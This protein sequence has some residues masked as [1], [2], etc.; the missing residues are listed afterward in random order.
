MITLSEALNTYVATNPR[1]NS[2]GTIRRY[3]AT[4]VSLGKFL[5]R[6]PLIADLNA[7][8]YGRWVRHRRDVVGV[9]P[10]TL[11]GEAQKLLVIWRWLAKR[12]EVAQPDVMLPRKFEKD[13]TTWVTDE[14]AKIEA[15]GRSCDWYVGQVP[16]SIYWPAMLGVAVESGER[17]GALHKLES[18]HFDFAAL[19]VTFPRHIRKGQT[20]DLTKSISL[21]T[22]TDVQ[23]L[24]ALRPMRPFAPLLQPSMY[25][26]MR[27]LLCDAGL[28]SDRSR[29]FHC[30]RRYH[31]TQVELMGGNAARSLDHSDPRVTARYIDTRQLGPQPMPSRPGAKREPTRW[32]GW[33]RRLV[34]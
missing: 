3:E 7:D 9:A 8:T 12:G 10:S 24:I 1:I 14:Y 5:E 28:P 33:L 2:D 17:L 19:T 4:I 25:H 27:R 13:N 15:A 11:H 20:R 30:L 16:G 6:D 29:L 18:H 22:A 34:G 31:A 21:Q 23:K 32:F 26:P